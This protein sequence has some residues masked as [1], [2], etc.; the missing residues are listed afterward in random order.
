MRGKQERKEKGEQ[1]IHAASQRIR[2]ARILNTRV[3]AQN[4][5]V[6]LRLAVELCVINVPGYTL[7]RFRVT[8]EMALSQSVRS[9]FSLRR[10]AGHLSTVRGSHSQER[11]RS[12]KAAQQIQPASQPGSMRPLLSLRSLALW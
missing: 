12:K 1:K 4:E 8:N 3:V 11:Q 10:P 7:M 2:E 6:D 9:D 5:T